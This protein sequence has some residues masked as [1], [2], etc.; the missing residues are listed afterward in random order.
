MAFLGPDD[1]LVLEKATGRVRRVQAGVLAP[2]PVLTVPVN[3]SSER[4]LL[5]IAVNT[6]VPPRVFLYFTEAATAGGAAIANRVYRYDWDPGSGLLV[7]PT[8][9]LDLPVLPG[10]NHNGGIVV[11]GPPGQAPGVG[12]GALLYAVIGDLNHAGQLQNIPAGATPDDTGVILRV[13]QDGSAAPG[14]PFAPYCSVTTTTT[15]TSNASC[16]GG[17]TCRL[18]VARYF[19]YGVRNSFGMTIDP[20]TGA[21]WDTENGPGDYDEVNLVAPGANSGW[22]PIMGPDARDPSGPGD[23]FDMPGAG[24]TY[25]DPE[26]SWLATIAPTGIAF[27]RNSSLGPAYESTALVG[28]A[29]YGQVYAFPL[30]GT[31]TGFDVSG[32]PGLGDLVADSST[33]RDAV[34]FGQ[35]FGLVS[36]LEMGPD[37]H[38]YVVSLTL[39][40]IFRVQGPP[41]IP[42]LPPWAALVLVAM[43]A[44][45]IPLYARA[46]SG[47]ERGAR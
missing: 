10:T 6:Q 4:G 47:L 44:S 17:E 32:I 20:V 23:L 9:V 13:R 37:G 5:G 40:S 19:A 31:R 30:D 2:A 3:A 24:S 28:D 16:P 45:S 1:I 15:C 43:L 29:N 21:L 39:G 7:A 38:L 46:R 36:D 26:F 14:N 41:Q 33:E 18:Q 34:R 8:L 25:S 35:G 12:D 42:A 22:I 27:P 11:L